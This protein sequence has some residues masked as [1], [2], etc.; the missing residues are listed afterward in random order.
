MEGSQ[1]TALTAELLDPLSDGFDTMDATAALLRSGRV[2]DVE[3]HRRPELRVEQRS[4]RGPPGSP[5]AASRMLHVDEDTHAHDLLAFHGFGPGR[6]RGRD[7]RR[8]RQPGRPRLPAAPEHRRPGAVVA[9]LSRRRCCCSRPASPVSR[10]SAAAAK[11][12]D[13][14]R[15]MNVSAALA[16]CS[17]AGVLGHARRLSPRPHVARPAVGE[18]RQL[19][20]RLPRRPLRRLLRVDAAAR[21]RVAADP[22]ALDRARSSSSASL[23]VLLAGRLG[24]ELFLARISL[25]GLIAGAVL[26]L[27]G[28]SS[29]PRARLPD[30]VPA[31][32]GAAARPSSSINWRFRCS[33]WRRAQGRPCCRRAAF[34]CCAKA[35]S[36]CCRRRRSR[37]SRRAAASARWSRC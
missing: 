24:A 5:T 11:P 32:D 21:T 15:S 20:A 3:Q 13:D 7:L 1:F 16:G 31:A 35:T 28:A 14:S 23:A 34:R 36:S 9:R 37:W 22:S 30:R 26:F 17:R 25:I 10:G 33:C 8:A 12:S 19:L 6:V 29:F 4:R 18:R 27:Y 2:L